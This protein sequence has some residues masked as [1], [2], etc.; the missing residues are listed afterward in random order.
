M[1]KIWFW[2]KD[3]RFALITKRMHIDK[4]LGEHGSYRIWWIYRVFDVIPICQI[5]DQVSL[6]PINN[7]KQP[8]FQ[9]STGWA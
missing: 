7:N 3:R 1:Q 5:Q 6:I 8:A 9:N 4:H 2:L